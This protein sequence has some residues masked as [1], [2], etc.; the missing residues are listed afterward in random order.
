MP[1]TNDFVEQP[2]L[3]LPACLPISACINKCGEERTTLE[4]PNWALQTPPSESTVAPSGK[5][6]SAIGIS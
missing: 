1:S 3:C 2:P 5:P 6:E 4:A